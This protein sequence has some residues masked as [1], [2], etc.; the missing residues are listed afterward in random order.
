[1]AAIAVF[2][3]VKA[4]PALQANKANFLTDADLEPERGDADL[5]HRGA[6]LRHRAQSSLLALVIA[7]PVAVGIALFISHYAPRRLAVGPRL[8]RRP[9]RRRPQ[10]RLR[11]VGRARSSCRTCTAASQ[12][13]QRRTS[14]GSRCSAATR[15]GG[16]SMLTAVDRAGDHDPADHRRD[17][18]RG[19]PPGPA[20]CNVEAA[21]ALGATALGDHPDGGAAV[22]PLRHDQRLDARPR[23][24]AGRDDRR[25]HGAVP[26]TFD[27]T[28]RDP[29]AR[30][31]HASPPT[32]PTASARPTATGRG[33]LIASGLVLFV[34]TLLVN[35][36]ARAIVARRKEFAR[37]A[38]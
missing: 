20:G 21:L 29:R 16:Q 5:R 12:L 26:A 22:R 4:V 1:M 34:I 27:I 19:L 33:A 7:V 9:A 24:R 17:H 31:Q 32:S 14:A 38:A 23:P 28:L 6:R 10:R 15:V 8:R 11:P 37:A 25:R 18:P 35:M 2:L 3:V 13:P 30:R 36:A